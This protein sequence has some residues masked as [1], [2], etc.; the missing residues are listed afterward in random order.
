MKAIHELTIFILILFSIIFSELYAAEL[1]S[2][3]VRTG[4]ISKQTISKTIHVYGTVLPDPDQSISL[5]LSHGGYITR[6]WCRL[7]QRVRKDD[8]L[9]E[10]DASPSGRMQFIQAQ[11]KVDFAR[12]ELAHQQRLEKEQLATRA[13]VEAARKVLLDAQTNLASLRKQGLEKTHET[14]V[15]PMDGIITQLNVTQGQ[16]VQ[17]ETT[18]MLIASED[19]LI[20]SLGVEPEDLKFIQPG[21]KV[22]LF[23][24]F[25]PDYKATTTV[26]EAH[27]MIN[28]NTHLVDVLA[29]IPDEQV[30]HLVLG[31]KM[32]ALIELAAHN[33][34]VVSRS[35]LL[36]DEKGDYIFL[37]SKGK[38]HRVAVNRGVDTRMFVEIQGEVQAG[39]I[40][41]VSGNYELKDGMSVRESG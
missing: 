41:V 3:L 22:T 4:T 30:D 10:L 12:Q 9:L 28:P 2:V 31:C 18:A 17:A 8:K 36:K 34:L 11:R 19:K 6:V 40:V 5:S 15:A 32:K 27:A 23:S 7:G 33:T 37:V 25:E 21:L 39:D 14:L 35:A 29:A 16:R 38:A 13:Q 20:V 26:R 24:V 1:P